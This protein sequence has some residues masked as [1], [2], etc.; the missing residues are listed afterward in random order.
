MASRPNKYY[1]RFGCTNAVGN[2]RTKEL[3]KREGRR[4]EYKQLPD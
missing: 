1:F 4:K 2:F 3:A